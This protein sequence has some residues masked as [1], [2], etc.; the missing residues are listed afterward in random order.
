[1]QPRFSQ[2]SPRQQQVTM[3]IASGLSF[4]Q[5]AQ[6]TGM[7]RGTIK[8]LIDAACAEVGARDSVELAAWFERGTR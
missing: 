6:A 4:K 3:L 5:I 8:V 2:L 1:M 7:A